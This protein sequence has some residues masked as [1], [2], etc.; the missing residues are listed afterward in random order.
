M[1]LAEDLEVLNLRAMAG[2][3]DLQE[4]H[5]DLAKLPV[6]LENQENGNYTVHLDRAFNGSDS[7]LQFNQSYTADPEI[8]KW[9]TNADFRRALSLGI[10][11]NQ[12]NETFWLGVGTPGSAAPGESMPL[13]PGPGVAHQVVDARSRARPTRCS[14]RIGLT[15]KDRD[16]F[17]LRTDNGE[18]LRLQIQAVQAFLP[19]PQQAEMV[20]AALAARSA[21]RPR[22]SEM[23]RMLAFTRTRNNEHHI[24]VWT[25]GGTE[26]LYLFPRHAIP[27]DPTE[28]FMG[29][30]FAKWYA[31]GGA[32]GRE[33]T[34][35]NL[36]KIFQLFRRRRR[37]EGATSAT[38]PRR[39]SGRSWS[40]SNTA[41]GT[42]GQSPA[43]MGVRLAQQQARQH[44]VAR[45]HRPALPHAGR[46]AAG[47]LVLSRNDVHARQCRHY[48]T[49]AIIGREACAWLRSSFG[50][51]CSP[52]VTIWAI[53]VLSFVIIQLP[54]GDFVD[55]YI[56]QPLRQRQ[57]GLDGGGGGAA[58]ALRPRSA[59]LGAIR[60]VDGARRR[61]RFRRVDGVEAGRSPK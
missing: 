43:L 23:E 32:P 39:R 21:S 18:R 47:D 58:P 7:T 61:R 3:Y 49:P 5:I 42:V 12:L 14:T 31:S 46:L 4:R 55:A 2:D 17:R 33:P 30:E 56:A 52:L 54:P 19:W 38:R 10:D 25:N 13:N 57:L 29:P 27:V 34:D 44:P 16:G 59:G 48:A 36:K 53:S 45:L 51:C 15:K 1:T 22:C 40:T 11:R 20:A 60:E 35:P 6:I 9:L 8:A 37:P 41:I 24:H 50:A 28:A 26:L